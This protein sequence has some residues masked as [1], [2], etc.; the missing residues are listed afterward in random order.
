[1]M[2]MLGSMFSDE[3][4]KTDIQEVGKDP[5]TG[6]TM[7]AFR[8]KGDPKNTPK[9][10][11]PMAQEVEKKYPG[12]TVNM[13]GGRVIKPDAVQALGRMAMGPGKIEKLGRMSKR[14]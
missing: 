9:V 4:A 7:H 6:L 8:Y 14:G 10:V 5:K 2:D 1:M 11:G 13:G 12:S 3:D